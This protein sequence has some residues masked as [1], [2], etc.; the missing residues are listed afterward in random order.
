MD[1]LGTLQTLIVFAGLF[2]LIGLAGL[3]GALSAPRR[4]P[5]RTALVQQYVG[6]SRKGG[7]GTGDRLPR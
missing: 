7:E 5:R 6:P 1:T 4:R 3:I 2:V